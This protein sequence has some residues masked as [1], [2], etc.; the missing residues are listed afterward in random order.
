MTL[1]RHIDE[2]GIRIEPSLLYRAGRRDEGLLGRILA[3]VRTPEERLGDL[4][5]QLAANHVGARSLRR[6]VERQGAQRLRQYG[7]ALLDYSQTFMARAIAAIPDGEYVA[8]DVLDDDGAGGGPVAIRL[9]LRIDGQRATLEPRD[10]DAQVPG[11]V[12]C[13]DA[14]TRSAVY[15]CFACLLEET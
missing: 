10:A 13:P 5:A 11:C 4:D 1:S 14:V 2:E 8:D 3:A 12:N 7:R 15:Y 6:I 9:R